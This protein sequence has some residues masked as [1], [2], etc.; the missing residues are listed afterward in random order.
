MSVP[1]KF[2]VKEEP[3][4]SDDSFRLYGD[5]GVVFLQ[6]AHAY[7]YIARRRKPSSWFVKVKAWEVDQLRLSYLDDVPLKQR[8]PTSKPPATKPATASASG[9]SLLPPILKKP[10]TITLPA[11]NTHKQQPLRSVTD[12]LRELK[13]PRE[14]DAPPTTPAAPVV[15][16]ARIGGADVAYSASTVAGEASAFAAALEHSNLPSQPSP[17][18]FDSALPTAPSN[19]DS[20]P[21]AAS[22]PL[23]LATSLHPSTTSHD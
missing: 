20:A 13:T 23:A 11:S 4:V 16:T 9:P 1:V 21:V 19:A 22:A 6:V 8:F 15:H 18:H 17:A 10:L 3:Q 14:E 5:H 2:G 12:I 7:R